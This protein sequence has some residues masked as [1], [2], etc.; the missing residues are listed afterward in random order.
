[1][2]YLGN[3]RYFLGMEVARNKMVILV[4]Q[5]KYVIDLLKET[6]MLGCKPVDTP[7]DLNVKLKLKTNSNPV[8]KGRYQHLAGKLIYLSHTRQNIAYYVSCVSQFMHSPS[9]MKAVYRI[10]KYLKGTPGKGLSFKKSE[11]RGVE[12]FTDVDWAGSISD[13]RST[14]GYC[15]FVWGNLVTWRSKKQAVVAR[16]SAEAE[17]RSVAHGICEALWLKILLEELKM[18]VATPLKIFCDNR[19]A[20]NISHNL[21]HHDRTKHVEVDRHL[22][23]RR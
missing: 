10:L 14:F 21:L 3:L 15:S 6:R 13:R 2:K 16:S 12:I 8:D 18:I 7:M 22:S 11:A 17:L 19:A 4:T 5:C 1:M 9:D 23:R 20:I